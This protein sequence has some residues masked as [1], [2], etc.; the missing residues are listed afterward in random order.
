MKSSVTLTV[1]AADQADRQ[2]AF[3]TLSG[4]AQEIQHLYEACNVS[5]YSHVDQ[6]G[7]FDGEEYFDEYTMLKVV[8]AFKLADVDD[9]H[10][11]AIIDKLRDA[12]ILFRERA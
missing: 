2:Q 12:G 3:R 11:E 7:R 10:A 6:D 4:L 9:A 5:S 1:C 8:N